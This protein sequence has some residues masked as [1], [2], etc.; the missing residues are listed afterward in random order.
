M[1]PGRVTDR[2]GSDRIGS[3]AAPRRARPAK[4][5]AP[6]IPAAPEHGPRAWMRRCNGRS[7]VVLLI[8]MMLLAPSRAPHCC[9]A[10]C[11][12]SARLHA[13]RR[14]TWAPGTGL[15]A[16]LSCFLLATFGALIGRPVSLWPQPRAFSY[17][18]V[19]PWHPL[20]LGGA[21]GPDEDDEAQSS[22]ASGTSG[23]GAM[24]MR[25]RESI[26]QLLC[27]TVRVPLEHTRTH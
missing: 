9:R 23:G 24:Q 22:L 26:R 4:T 20:T 27:L 15:A 1:R 21:C 19:R 3:D 17:A 25:P 7:S 10:S 8:M 2:I 13:R 6:P 11:C 16:L 14:Y 18:S 12:A 5:L